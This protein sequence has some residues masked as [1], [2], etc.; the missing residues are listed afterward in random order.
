MVW[1]SGRSTKIERGGLADAVMVL[2]E[3]N[4]TVG[5]PAASRWRAIR[6]TDWWQTGQTGTSSTRSGSWAAHRSTSHLAVSASIRR[7]E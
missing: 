5:I 3:V 7:I 2:A 4:P 1:P 6:P